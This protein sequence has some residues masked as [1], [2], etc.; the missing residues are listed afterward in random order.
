MLFSLTCL[1]P[2]IVSMYFEVSPTGRQVRQRYHAAHHQGCSRVDISTNQTKLCLAS[3][4]R[5]SEREK[6]IEE[7]GESEKDI[8]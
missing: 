6:E 4:T 7:E 8:T 1:T 5:E 3:T 2:I